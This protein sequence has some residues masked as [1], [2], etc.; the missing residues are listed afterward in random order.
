VL[1]L[2]HQST[3][4]FI[5]LLMAFGSFYVASYVLH[6]SGVLTTASATLVA[7]LCLKDPRPCTETVDQSWQWIWL[8]LQALA[9]VLLGLLVS[10]AM[11][12]AQWQ[13]VLLAMFAS[14]CGRA[15]S[16]YSMS[17]LGRPQKSLPKGWPALLT[18][19]G[20]RGTLA[21]ALALALP[22]S[23]PYWHNIQAIVF[24]VVITNT[25]LQTPSL[26]WHIRRQTITRGNPI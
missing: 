18:W 7:K 21:I 24:A 3:S 13:L 22:T 9:F 16:V 11:F 23:L 10:P 6:I 14:I 12:A 19:A 20:S 1:L 17:W 8:L 26:L 15:V 25:F 5:L 4:T 2:N